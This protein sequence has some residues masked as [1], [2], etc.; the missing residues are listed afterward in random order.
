MKLILLLIN[1]FSAVCCFSQRDP[2]QMLRAFP[3]TSYIVKLNDSVNV[4]QVKLPEGTKMPD[5]QL[6]LLK[7]IFRNSPDDTVQKGYGRCHLVKGNYYYFSIGNNNSGRAISEG[8][9]L[10]SFMPVQEIHIERFAQLA[11]HQIGLLDVYEKGFYDRYQIF[12]SW[13][14]VDEEQVMDSIVA[15]LKFT[16]EYFSKNSPDMDKAVA[17]GPFKGKMIFAVMKSCELKTVTD[18]LDYL[19]ARPR[20]YAG[21]EW[22]VSEIFAT[23]VVNG[24]PA[25]VKN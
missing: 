5:K 2:G 15:D 16:G 3:V 11:S 18:F 10:Y 8:D 14:K 7:G 22:K 20:L 4:V 23:W 17:L 6:G 21:K 19:I 1:L 24:A 9:L 25:I 12:Q 13:N